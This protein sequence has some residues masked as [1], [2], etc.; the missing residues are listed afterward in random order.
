[1][2]LR[3]RKYVLLAITVLVAVLYSLLAGGWTDA[4]SYGGGAALIA[5]IVLVG[6][7]WLELASDGVWRRWTD[8]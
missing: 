8:A 4:A 5:V 3:T 2:T 1:M 7:P 6:L